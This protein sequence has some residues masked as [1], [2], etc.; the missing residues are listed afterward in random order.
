MRKLTLYFKDKKLESH[1]VHDGTLIGRDSRCD[2]VIDSLAI[3]KQ[4]ARLDFIGKTVSIV[5]LGSGF[6]INGTQQQTSA[7]LQPGD[8][9][10]IGK[11]T[12]LYQEE[13]SFNDELSEP[14]HD[15]T[16]NSDDNE[17]GVLHRTK[18]QEAFLQIMNGA[19]VGKTITLNRNMT[20]IGKAGV[21]A[22][23]IIRRDSGFYLS[24][25]EGKSSPQVN[26]R[27]I[28]DNSHQ[29]ENGDQ[30]QLGNIKLLFTL[31]S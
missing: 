25:L 12:L 5:N 1:P 19:N 6:Q 29:L 18:P 8:E 26:G 23:V 14:Q 10:G 13:E 2:I 24:H 30:L 3:N 22:A 15:P 31:G 16:A 17:S 21:Q 28:G 7:L 4:H 27:A 20:N 11:H 9:I